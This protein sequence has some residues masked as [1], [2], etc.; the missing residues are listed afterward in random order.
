MQALLQ[1][2]PGRTNEGDIDGMLLDLGISSMQVNTRPHVP[3]IV[4][5]LYK[6]SALLY[7]FAILP[8]SHGLLRRT[9]VP[10]APVASLEATLQSHAQD[11]LESS[12]QVHAS[13]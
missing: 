10:I 3:C 5:S 9:W 2:L 1:Q 7:L 6:D 13:R 4:A 12:T 8:V 11:H